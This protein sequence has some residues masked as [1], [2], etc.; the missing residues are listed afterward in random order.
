MPD[1]ANDRGLLYGDGLF[2]TILVVNGYAPLIGW[3]I[4]RMHAGIMAL[5]LPVSQHQVRHRLHQAVSM[6]TA[7]E[8]VVKVVLTRGK[9]E[10]GYA[11]PAKAKPSWIISHGLYQRRQKALYDD[12][13]HIGLCQQALTP[14]GPLAGLKHLNRLEQVLAAQQVQSHGWDEGLML[15]QK[16]SPIELTA[17]NLFARFGNAIW[18]SPV[19]NEG[20][21]GVL[22]SWLQQ[23]WLPSS[24][25]SLL[26][27][28]ITLAK[29]QQADE[30]IAGNSVAGFLPVRKL[31][32]W[33]WQPGELIGELQSAFESLIQR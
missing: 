5:N 13:L 16:G 9:G 30:V 22:R 33:T 12:G 28:P 7:G 29:L 8:Q 31:G 14:A 1:Y 18:M 19:A 23:V 24:D 26:N 20:V 32:L 15:N 11:P 4:K 2:E 3:H 17:M 6:A 25:Y 10:R 21:A 27:Q